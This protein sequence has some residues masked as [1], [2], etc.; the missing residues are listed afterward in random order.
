M[1]DNVPRP[2]LTIVL[3]TYNRAGVLDKALRWMRPQVE[4]FGNAIEVIVSNNHSTDHTTDVLRQLEGWSQARVVQPHQHV[5]AHEHFLWLGTELPRAEY[6][7]MLGDDDFPLKEGLAR[8]LAA[9][10][11]P[12]AAEYLIL[13]VA[14]LHLDRWLELSAGRSEMQMSELCLSRITP[15][16][17]DKKSDHL[18]DILECG[19]GD[20]FIA[21]GIPAHI[22]KPAVWRAR[23]AELNLM[24]TSNDGRFTNLNNTFPHLSILY[25]C[26]GHCRFQF[27]H[28]ACAVQSCGAQEWAADQLKLLTNAH[29]YILAQYRRLGVSEAYL[30]QAE[31]HYMSHQWKTVVGFF[32]Q[33]RNLPELRRCVQIINRS[34]P[35]VF[36]KLRSLRALVPY[37]A[38]NAY[39]M[40]PERLKNLWRGM[41]RP[42][43]A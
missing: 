33:N 18:R 17:E 6:C 23:I 19:G 37:L 30:N 40:L 10:T 31:R 38:N 34:Q 29:P 11:A 2:T 1:P 22:F 27:I 35:G 13:N 20:I 7:W 24:H 8:V 28:D 4:P 32:S 14:V 42:A 3:P 15:H 41:K 36:G 43:R 39:G 25:A 5:P 21:C 9:I 16:A 26:E 12:N